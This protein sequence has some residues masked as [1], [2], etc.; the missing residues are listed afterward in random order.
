VLRSLCA[1]LV[2]SGCGRIHFDEIHGMLDDAATRDVATGDGSG[3]VAAVKSFVGRGNN[4]G[5]LTDSFVAQAE[6]A[7]DAI[8]IHATCSVTSGTATGVIVTAPN[9]TLVQLD[10]IAGMGGSIGIWGASLVAI[11]PDTAPATFSVTWSIP[12][13]GCEL[14]TELGYEFT[15]NDPAGGS[16]T[17]SSHATTL[18]GNRCAATLT[19]ANANDAVFAACSTSNGQVTALDPGFSAGPTDGVGDAAEYRVTSDPAGTV[20]SI[21]ISV[22]TG[23]TLVTATTIKP[24]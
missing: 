20:E 23:L 10:P 3:A 15:N 18:G 1:F 13:A 19:T 24:R 21:S 22:D 9:W 11:A 2:I 6:H 4:S 8:V 16:T 12:G 7:G 17:F 14:V 5:G